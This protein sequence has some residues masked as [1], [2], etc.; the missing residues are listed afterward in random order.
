METSLWTSYRFASGTNLAMEMEKRAIAIDG[1]GGK[2]TID[3]F[4]SYPGCGTY[5]DDQALNAIET[6]EKLA[7]ILFNLI[8]QKNGI[9]ID[10]QLV[11]S[12]TYEEN[13]L[14]K[15]A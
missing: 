12:L 2:M 11:I 15:A 6:V 10:N 7:I 9:P 1:K 13:N 3:K 8:S 14:N 4:K 5:T